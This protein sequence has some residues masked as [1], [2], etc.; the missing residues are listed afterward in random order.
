MMYF[1]HPLPLLTPIAFIA[2]SH[3]PSQIHAFSIISINGQLKFHDSARLFSTLSLSNDGLVTHNNIQPVDNRPHE[4]RVDAPR[5]ARRLNHAFQH[6]YRHSDPRWD[7]NDWDV[8]Y[9]WHDVDFQQN[10]N[11]MFGSMDSNSTTA[12]RPLNHNMALSA[13]HYLHLY[14]GYSLEEIRDM[15]E[16]FPPLFEIDVVRHLRPKMR[17]LKDCMGGGVNLGTATSKRQVL[18]PELRAVL[19]ASFFGARFERTIAPRHAFLVHANLPNGKTLW[20]TDVDGRS[21]LEEFLMMHRK[22]K[23]F[24]AMC[25]AWQNL[26]ST[27]THSNSLPITANQIVAFDKLF[28]RGLLSAARNDTSYTFPDERNKQP[29]LSGPC[30]MKTANVTAGQLIR[31]L[32]QH[33][34]NPYE[35]DVRG[36]SLFHWAAG[37]GNLEALQEL[38]TSCNE[39]DFDRMATNETQATEN[40]Q[41]CYG[42]QAALLWKASRDNAT[43]L[44]WAAAGAGVK[45]FGKRLLIMHDILHSS[46]HFDTSISSLIMC[47]CRCWR[48]CIHC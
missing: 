13:I 8:G 7:D 29:A 18:C 36:A 39:L 47:I 5:N 46:A 3:T 15:H 22:P 6:L 2:T 45:E 44:H 17:F 38:V 32:I 42:V 37:C 1:N 4:Q 26:Y 35:E 25:N 19:P 40:S 21:L 20:E 28:Q 24:A 48:T 33:G 30:M 14:G 34:G 23:Q 31:Y 12:E 11:S 43:P 16:S 41:S 9:Q 10:V 27:K